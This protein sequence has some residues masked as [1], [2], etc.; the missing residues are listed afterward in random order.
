MLGISSCSA[1]GVGVRC[2]LMRW[3][4][5]VVMLFFVVQMVGLKRNVSCRLLTATKL[6]V[7]GC[8]R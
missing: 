8:F 7:S 4:G 2:I 6:S 5:H 3:D 1:Q